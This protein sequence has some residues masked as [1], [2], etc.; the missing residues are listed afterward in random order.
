MTDEQKVYIRGVK[1]RGIDVIAALDRLGGKTDRLGYIRLCALGNIPFNVFIIGHDGEIAYM[2]SEGEVFEIIKDSYREIKLPEQW[3]DGDILVNRYYSDCFAVCKS[4]SK[5]RDDVYHFYIY[6]QDLGCNGI[7]IDAYGG[8][9]LR[10]TYRLA[11][12]SEIEHFHELLHKYGKDWDA[13]KKQLVDCQWKPKE[14]EIYWYIS[15][16]G[17]LASGVFSNDEIDNG[18]Y[19]F[20]N[21]FRTEEEAK[22]AYERVKK[23]LKG[24]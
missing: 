17:H 6:V 4:P 12:S 15:A 13:E 1:G 16:D 2:D 7:D 22:A 14:R 10:S 11:A 9:I 20:G 24:E 8:N 23:A 21:C 5:T 18:S 19:D 3:K